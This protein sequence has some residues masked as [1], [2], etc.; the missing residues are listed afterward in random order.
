MSNKDNRLY[1][2]IHIDKETSQKLFSQYDNRIQILQ[3][4]G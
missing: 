1:D 3:M 4:I 2:Y